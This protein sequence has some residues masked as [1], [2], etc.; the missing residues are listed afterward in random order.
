MTK[1][2]AEQFADDAI[3]IMRDGDDI[4]HLVIKQADGTETTE[5]EFIYFAHAI[6]QACIRAEVDIPPTGCS[7]DFQAD[8]MACGV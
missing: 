6:Q 1:Y 3:A 4:L 7:H 5:A 2:T 8:I